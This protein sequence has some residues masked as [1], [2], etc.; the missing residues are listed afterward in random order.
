MVEESLH[1]NYS[2]LGSLRNLSGTLFLGGE[3]QVSVFHREAF[4]KKE[5]ETNWKNFV[6]KRKEKKNNWRSNI[7]DEQSG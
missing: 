3:E 7:S 6:L 1:Q 5:L 4:Y 2:L